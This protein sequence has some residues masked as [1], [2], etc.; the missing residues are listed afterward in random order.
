MKKWKQN[1]FSIYMFNGVTVSKQISWLWLKKKSYP[2]RPGSGGWPRFV[3]G[4]LLLVGTDTGIDLC[5]SQPPQSKEEQKL[6]GSRH[7]LI[8]VVDTGNFSLFSSP[9]GT[10]LMKFENTTKRTRLKL[11]LF[12]PEISWKVRLSDLGS[13]IYIQDRV[14]DEPWIVN[15]N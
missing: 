1:S 5:C 12:G 9:L 15:K 3:S 6:S 11:V 10:R 13:T 7:V 4:S 8:K 14:F 2:I